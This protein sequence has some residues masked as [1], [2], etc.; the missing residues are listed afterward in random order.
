MTPT[1]TQT[2]NGWSVSLPH[3]TMNGFKTQAK[4]LKAAETEIAFMNFEG[5]TIED[6]LRE[7]GL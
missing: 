3:I 1:L 5:E 4:A 6:R 2:P 7:I